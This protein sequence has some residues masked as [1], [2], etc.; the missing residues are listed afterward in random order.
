[1]CACL[2]DIHPAP[3]RY[4]MNAHGHRRIPRPRSSRTA[5]KRKDGTAVYEE[6]RAEAGSG[7]LMIIIRTGSSVSHLGI[8]NSRASATWAVETL[9]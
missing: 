4:A 1:M 2:L 6:L 8:G 5:V 7:K 9:T 3:S